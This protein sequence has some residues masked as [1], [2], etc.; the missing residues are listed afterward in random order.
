M[1]NEFNNLCHQ[2]D[3][4]NDAN[5]V[6]RGGV[7]GN[8]NQEI[9]A[10]LD[11]ESNK[12]ANTT[13]SQATHKEELVTGTNRSNYL[14]RKLTIEEEDTVVR[15]LSPGALL[16]SSI[17]Q[18]DL[19]TLAGRKSGGKLNTAI[20]EMYSQVVLKQC[21]KKLCLQ[22]QE[23]SQSL[24]YGSEFINKYFEKQMMKSIIIIR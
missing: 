5:L 21:D 14:K 8:N 11:A 16:P 22:E 18:K 24:F 6:E 15:A 1:D 7:T 3:T 23:R 19:L 2:D 13:Y 10:E 4:Y 20:I 17:N 9:A 12:T